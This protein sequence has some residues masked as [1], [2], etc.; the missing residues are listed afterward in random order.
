MKQTMR[1]TWRMSR[2]NLWYALLL[3]LFLAG[4]ARANHL[5]GYDWL[6]RPLGGDQYRLTLR[7]YTDGNA[8]NAPLDQ[9]LT[10]ATFAQRRPTGGGSGLVETFAL[11]LTGDGVVA[12]TDPVCSSQTTPIRA[13]TYTADVFLPAGRYADPNG[14]YLAWERCCRN[15]ALTNV[16]NPTRVGLAAVLTFPPLLISGAAQPYTS[17]VFRAPPPGAAWCVGAPARL[18]FNALTPPDADSLVYS[19]MPALAGFTTQSDSQLPIPNSGPYPPV[20]YRPGFSAAG[21]LPGAFALNAR[22]GE[23]RGVPQQAGV[24]VVAVAA[25]VYRNGRVRGQ[26]RREI[27]VRVANCPTNAR[28]TLARA[29]GRPAADTLFITDAASRCLT[30]RV[31]DADAGQLLTLGAAG[32]PARLSATT[33][34]IANPAIAQTVTVCWTQCATPARQT[35]RLWV[36]DD[37]CTG[38]ATS[39]T[40]RIPVVV[41]PL[42][43]Q[44]PRLTLVAGL[45]TDTLQVRAGEELTIALT[46]A[47]PDGGPLILTT[48]LDGAPS[49]AAL[50]LTPAVGPSPLMAT[51]RWT[52]SC[53]E[54]RAAPSVLTVR[55]NDGGCRAGQDS[56]QLLVRVRATMEPT[57]VSLT[58]I[59]TPNGDEYN[60]CFGLP[61]ALR[62]PDTGCGGGF[63]SITIC[64][65][66]GRVVF[67]STDPA[68]CW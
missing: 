8:Q 34:M 20:V 61:D 52:P 54:P 43:N 46:A 53:A 50:T 27:E 56:L 26:S 65:R 10:V 5:T 66:W 35:L 45:P 33:L 32:A 40:L 1:D 67:Q 44:P 13:L 14:Y 59:I 21:P 29:D 22:T 15:E 17:P 49:P 42:P 4:P 11:P 2:L 9:I 19:L 3:L 12:T 47:D 51:V 60:D 64:N 30:L 23:L 38:A 36:R 7:L 6:L 28:P 58:D 62:L 31:F 37:A 55:A 39:D 41:R 16:A 48:R 68:F 18:S 63:R 57:A 25:T 24:Y